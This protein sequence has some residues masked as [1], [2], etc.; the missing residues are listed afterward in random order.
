DDIGVYFWLVVQR[1]PPLAVA[2]LVDALNP[3]LEA[4]LDPFAPELVGDNPARHF[5]QGVCHDLGV[6]VDEYALARQLPHG[7]SRLTSGETA[8]HDRHA[9]GIPKTV[10]QCPGIL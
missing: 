5:A 6:R 2:A 8:T 10:A 7:P 3:A 4:E 9:V 1:Q